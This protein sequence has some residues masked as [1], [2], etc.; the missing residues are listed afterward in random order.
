MKDKWYGDNRDLIKGSVLTYLCDKFEAH[1]IIQIAYYKESDFSSISIDKES[2]KVSQEVKDHFR[3]ILNAVHIES[4]ERIVIFNE[5]FVDRPSYLKA[6]IAFIKSFSSKLCIVF[7]DPDTGLEPQ[8]FGYQHILNDEV[9]TLWKSLR[10]GSVLVLYQHRTSLSNKDWKE[11][12]REQLARS[13]QIDLNR[14]KVAS[15]EIAKDMV[16]FYCQK[17]ED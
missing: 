13:L 15:S 2:I 8:N 9:N 11:L 7:L 16:L 12:K 14:I 10:N 17:N 1:K 4:K 6:A 5:P 3:N